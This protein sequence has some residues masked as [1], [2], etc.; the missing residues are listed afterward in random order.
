MKPFASYRNPFRDAASERRPAKEI[1]QYTF[2]AL[3]AWAR[4]HNV[5]RQSGETPLEFAAR[6][7]EEFPG[8]E[9]DVRRFTVLYARA[10]YDYGPLPANALDGVA[11]FW[12]RLETAAEQP[13]SV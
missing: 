7:G 9:A 5:E 1:V 3:Q 12:K 6:L 8:L 13:M 11:A 10:V 2:A 4:E